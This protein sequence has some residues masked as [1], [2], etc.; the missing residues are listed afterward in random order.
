MKIEIVV[1]SYFCVVKVPKICL[2]QF[3]KTANSVSEGVAYRN[4]T[5]KMIEYLYFHI[6]KVLELAFNC[7]IM[8]SLK[9][10]LNPQ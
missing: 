1:S 6:M 5:T 9:L 7:I 10:F 8:T 3:W 4:Y 2:E